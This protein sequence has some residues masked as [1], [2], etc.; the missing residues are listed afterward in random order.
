MSRNITVVLLYHRHKLLDPLHSL[1][2]SRD[3]VKTEAEETA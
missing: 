2:N 3:N 1:D